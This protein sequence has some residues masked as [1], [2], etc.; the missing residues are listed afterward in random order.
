[1]SNSKNATVISVVA[2]VITLAS[3]E[4]LP[5]SASSSTAAPA[6][7][8]SVVVANSAALPAQAEAK[9]TSTP[10]PL[11]AREEQLEEVIVTATRFSTSIEK[12]PISISALTQNDLI[13]RGIE[14][15]SDIAAVTPGLQ[16]TAPNAYMGTITEISIRGLNTVTG[17]SVVGIYL[18]DTP[19][20]SRISPVGN[21]GSPYPLVF[22]LNRVEVERGPQGTLFGAGS[23][24]GTVR[25]ISNEPSLDT[26]SGFAHSEAGFTQNGDPSAEIGA[27]AGGPIFDDTVG[28]RVSVWDR[29]DGGFVDRIDQVTGATTAKNTNTDDKFAVRGALK[30]KFDDTVS[31]TPSIYYQSIHQGDDGRIWEAFSNPS[32]GGFN[33]GAWL[34]DRSNDSLFLPALKAEAP[35]TFADLT[36]TAS[37]TD[38]KVNVRNDQS[39]F[40]GAF[41]VLNFGSPL[42]AGFSTSAADVA[43][44]YTGLTTKAYTEELRLASNHPDSFVTWVAGIFNDHR[45]QED[46][47]L[48]YSLLA[49]PT[50]AP[51]GLY[52]QT[53]VDEQTAIFAQGDFHLTK[54]LTAT[55]GAREAHVKTSQLNI[56]GTGLFNAGQPPTVT[57]GL[58]ETPFTPR[59]SLSYQMN[60]RNLIY[61]SA[62]KG[63]RVG[64]GN[65]PVPD[66]CSIVAPESYK[67]DYV[68]SYEVGAKDT[69]FGGKLQVDSSV[70]HINWSQIQ[71]VV[72]L[73]CGQ[74]YTANAG[75]A[76]SNGFDLAMQALITDQFRLNLNAGFSNA[77]FTE[78]VYAPG[79]APII[80]KGDKVGL[81]PQVNS[82]WDVDASAIYDIPLR[83][84][85]KLSLRSELQYHSHN[86]GPFMTQIP[87]SPS[88]APLSVSDPA[89]YLLNLRVDYLKDAWDVAMFVDNALDSHPELGKT[90]F[91]AI[92]NLITYSTFRPRTLGLALNWK[93]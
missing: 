33:G 67:S 79:G 3:S 11:L 62:G 12:V 76:T 91:S 24:A 22:D 6:G 70:F 39:G 52:Y 86:P 90:Q 72:Q 25:F 5:Q 42:G 19:I 7:N 54:Q 73:Q 58:S 49:D 43:P 44:T 38:R 28:Y 2:L 83:D 40:F 66:F 20:M 48:F 18:D 84:I 75:Y 27:A 56:N 31:V 36:F 1:M 10:S 71:Q 4:A 82:P 45:N 35:L 69:L 26:F 29:H 59:F 92:S 13:V 78:N 9:A 30:I 17:A 34:P 85:G 87:T 81:L 88:Y 21:V 37:Y 51:I 8:A 80:L 61:A 53:I 63:F 55:F 89:T 68:W 46:Y 15:I 41:G 77:H 16:F 93:F 60:D 50:G 47:A 65:E 57:S 74:Q 23:E 64:G 14:S 32:L